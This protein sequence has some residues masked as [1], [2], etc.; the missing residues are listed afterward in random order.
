MRTDERLHLTLSTFFDIFI[1]GKK[2]VMILEV[3][4]LDVE[5]TQTSEFEQ[6]F[7]QAQKIISKL[8]GYIGHELKRCLE[9]SSRYILRFD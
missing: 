9:N 6:A 7:L 3:A 5:P 2:V 8:P 4:I 1:L